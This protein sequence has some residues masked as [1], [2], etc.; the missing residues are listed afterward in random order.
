MSKIVLIGAKV[1][2]KRSFPFYS[3]SPIPKENRN[4]QTLS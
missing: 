4:K 3:N 2:R 1:G